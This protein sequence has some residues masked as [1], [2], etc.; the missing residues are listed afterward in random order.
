MPTKRKRRAHA[1]TLP[2]EVWLM[3][4]IGAGANTCPD[5][6]LRAT[7]REWGPAAVARGRREYGE[8][9]VPFVA[10]VAEAEGWD[11]RAD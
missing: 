2:R 1:S 3:L 6:E 5:A 7:W 11:G 8:A 4:S 10:R 9:W